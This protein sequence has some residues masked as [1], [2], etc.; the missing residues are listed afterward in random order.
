MPFLKDD[1]IWSEILKRSDLGEDTEYLQF[2]T[3]EFKRSTIF[4]R[5]LLDFD[6]PEEVIQKL[7]LASAS[8]DYQLRVTE[9]W[10]TMSD[11]QLAVGDVSW[12]W[13]SWIPKEMITLLAGEP[14][15][16]K[17][18]LAL[19]FCKLVAEGLAFPGSVALEPRNVIYV[20]AE[21][22]QVITKE[23]CISMGLPL[24]KVYVPNLGNDM[25]AQPDLNNEEH[26]DQ[27]E[28]MVADIKPA[29]IVVDSMGGIKSGGEN[30]KEEMQPTML[31]L[32]RLVQNNDCG[33]VVLHHLNKTKR[34]EDEEITLNHLRGSTTIAQFARSVMFLAKKPQ[35]MK[36]WVGKSNIA[37][38]GEGLQV[39]PHFSDDEKE[40]VITGFDF[41]IWSEQQK[42]T[43][44]DE[45][46]TWVIEHLLR[47]DQLRNVSTNIFEL[48]D[49]TWTRRTIKDAGAILERKGLI[50]RSGGKGSIW[51]LVQRPMRENHNGH[52]M[53]LIEEGED[54]SNNGHLQ[55]VRL[56]EEVDESDRRLTD[57]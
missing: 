42:T 20:D 53:K 41:E 43:K 29:L 34:E 7:R 24:D 15:T 50:S 18:Q 30:R 57:D 45:C 13:N 40:S 31:Y 55:E 9:K 4:L 5:R 10:A 56:S 37:K 8:F 16:G 26:R 44:I 14:G 19:W 47:Q 52:G 54:I 39:N 3:H 17:S 35:G 51:Q 27:L 21:A 12:L 33:I 2:T 49:E 23:R 46:Q 28:N 48:G 22:A 32:T 11:L 36:L 6:M 38:I 1:Q 25:L